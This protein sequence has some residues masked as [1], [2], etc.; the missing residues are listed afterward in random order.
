MG[1]GRCSHAF[2]D[3]VASNWQYHEECSSEAKFA[4]MR[5]DNAQT[6]AGIVALK[7][8]P[9]ASANIVISTRDYS[10]EIHIIK[11]LK[12]KFIQSIETK[13]AR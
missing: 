1:E 12:T 3:L 9:L 13:N 11:D 5:Q 2:A 7:D 10:W 6:A 8:H 4:Y